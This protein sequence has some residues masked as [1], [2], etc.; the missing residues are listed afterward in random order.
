MKGKVTFLKYV[1][2]M[3]KAGKSAEEIDKDCRTGFL[4][5]IA[6]RNSILVKQILIFSGMLLR[7]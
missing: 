2:K 3:K 6:L 4:R 7:M 1:K 5:E